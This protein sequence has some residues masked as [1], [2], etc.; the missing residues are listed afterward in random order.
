MPMPNYLTKNKDITN[1][2][3]YVP[4]Q[5]LSV[6]RKHRNIWQNQKVIYPDCSGVF[7]VFSDESEDT[8]IIC[9]NK[10]NEIIYI[11]QKQ[12]KIK[13]HTVTRLKEDMKVSDIYITKTGIGLNILYTVEYPEHTLLVHCLLGNN[14]LPNTL[15]KISSKSFFIFKNRVYY[16]DHEG[17]L[18]YRDFSDGKPDAFNRLV[19]DAE[20]PYLINHNSQDMLTYKKDREIYFQNRPVQREPDASSPILV[21]NNRELLL[22]WQ[23]GD[24]IRYILSTDDGKTWS[25]VMQFVNPGKKTQTYYVINNCEF[26]MYFGNHSSTE[27]HIYGTTDIFPTPKKKGGSAP[28]FQPDPNQLTKL[29]ILIE[30]Q[31]K[32]ITELKSEIAKLGHIIKCISD[33]STENPEEKPCDKK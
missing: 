19:K 24:F 21:S 18:G 5:G 27:L 17:F 6:R 9:V 22:M 7:S 16:K 28:F 3:F 23:K 1:H 30:M 13:T 25:D 29:K 12:D 2:Y 8:H 4:N 32:E 33:D 10:Q 11:L 15:D 14:A 31:K 26:Y 20:C